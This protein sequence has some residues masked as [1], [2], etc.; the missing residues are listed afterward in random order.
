M[1]ATP[2]AVEQALGAPAFKG[3]DGDARIWRYSGTTCAV[4]IFFY[5]GEGGLVRSAHVDA[6][7]LSG[8]SADVSA[9]LREVVNTPQA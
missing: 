3:H 8:G 7:R 1:D 2:Q 4:L 9:C 5:E 6:R